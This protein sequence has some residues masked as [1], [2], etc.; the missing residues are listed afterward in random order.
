MSRLVFY[1]LSSISCRIWARWNGTIF[2]SVLWVLYASTGQIAGSN[3]TCIHRCH[4][5]IWLAK[6]ERELADWKK[7]PFFIDWLLVHA[8]KAM[9]LML[10]VWLVFFF[11][12]D[13]FISSCF[14]LEHHPFIMVHCKDKM[15]YHENLAI[16]YKKC[17]HLHD[18]RG[19]AAFFIF[20]K[21]LF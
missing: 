17:Y 9:V 7:L 5:V 10:L 13:C 21:L 12:I 6:L 16:I 4:C 19:L 8:P 15:K 1:S 2:V 3:A 20:L 14:P 18:L 11:P